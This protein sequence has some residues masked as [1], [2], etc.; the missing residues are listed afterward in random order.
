MSTGVLYNKDKNP[1]TLKTLENIYLI[2]Q[3]ELQNSKSQA[4]IY[5]QQYEIINAKANERFS[6]EKYNKI[7]TYNIG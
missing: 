5:K 2:R 7:L 3:K 1:N 6:A 4:K